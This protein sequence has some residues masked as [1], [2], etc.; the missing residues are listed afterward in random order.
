MHFAYF[1]KVIEKPRK[2]RHNGEDGESSE[3][4]E[5]DMEVDGKENEYDFREGTPVNQIEKPKKKPRKEQ[6]EE[7]E[8]PLPST[9]ST[10]ASIGLVDRLD[11]FRSL[12]NKAFRKTAG[13][14][15][16]PIKDIMEF[17]AAESLKTPFTQEE[18]ELALDK[19]SEANQLMVSEDIVYLI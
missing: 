19:M 16:M 10:P 12:L 15:Q 3:E 17:L 14:Q 4:E 2:R 1:K 18:V 9:S 7:E 11:E 8:A 13:T 5:E 6:P